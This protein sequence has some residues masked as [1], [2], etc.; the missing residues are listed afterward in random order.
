MVVG[1]SKVS[2]TRD[3]LIT[4]D[5]V[6]GNDLEGEALI[7]GRDCRIDGNAYGGTLT[8]RAGSVVGGDAHV[9]LFKGPG[10]VEGTLGAAHLYPTPDL[11]P[12]LPAVPGEPDADVKV[13]KSE[14]YS[15]AAGSYDILTL[16][17]GTEAAPTVITLEGGEYHFKKIV[18]KNFTRLECAAPC[19]IRV[20]TS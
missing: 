20:A 1:F 10:T 17:P 16:L 19:D 3:V 4:G 8:S 14:A 15:L 13:P 7:V 12:A 6:S 5:V 9:D 2:L 11:P 18:Q